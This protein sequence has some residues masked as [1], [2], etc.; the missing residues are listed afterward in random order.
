MAFQINTTEVISDTL[1]LNNIASIDATTA[2]SISAAG[3]GGGGTQSFTADGAISAGDTVVLNSDGTVSS[4]SIVSGTS[5]DAYLDITWNVDSYGTS[6]ASFDSTVYG[7][8][9]V[10]HSVLRDGSLVRVK[11]AHNISGT[12]QLNS[13]SNPW[14]ISVPGT[15]DALVFYIDAATG[16]QVYYRY[17]TQSGTSYSAG[18]ETG[19]FTFPYQS[20]PVPRVV[21]DENND[22]YIG[23]F[24]EYTGSTFSFSYA[25]ATLSGTTLT[26]GSR[27]TGIMTG[28]RGRDGMFLCLEK[29]TGKVVLS[30]NSRVLVGT[31]S[32]G[33]VS[34]GTA[35]DLSTT[36]TAR[37][38]GQVSL[39][40]SGKGMCFYVRG[41]PYEGWAHPF[42]VSGTTITAGTRTRI[43]TYNFLS[44]LVAGEYSY[45]LDAW[46][47][48]Y[49]NTSGQLEYN[50][51]TTD[52]STVTNVSGRNLT[53]LTGN[54]N[55]SWY[56]AQLAG[57]NYYLNVDGNGR[58]TVEYV[59]DTTDADDWV[60]ISTSAISST[61][62][63]DI[64]IIGG[65]NDQQSGLTIGTTY[66]VGNDG[67]LQTASN[68]RKIGKALSATELLITEANT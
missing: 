17:L 45:D 37:A 13:R 12:Y 50:V 40:P 9:P 6:N 66:Y 29:T 52:G 8:T 21:Y 51:A 15:R 49:K 43:S 33:S 48:T 62:S 56:T 19:I 2:A 36:S 64:T 28:D 57:T 3:V 10:A 42:S 16:P 55:A 22:Q 26:W 18:S 68:G 5:D 11:A 38:G 65:V 41:A 7:T 54:S 59:P 20:S 25:I 31:V 34:W 63:G 30:S 53:G 58:T 32:S 27:T 23:V 47:Y 46:V 61:A 39:N 14:V 60:G 24:A 44:N 1:G 4:V 35:V 67:T